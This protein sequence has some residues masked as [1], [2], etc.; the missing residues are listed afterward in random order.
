MTKLSWQQAVNQ[1]F[2]RAHT[3][4]SKGNEGQARVCARRAAGIAIGEYL[5]R[6][7]L[8]NPGP[9][10]IDRLKFLTTQPDISPEV[11]RAIQHL[12]QRVDTNHNLPAGVDLIQEAN[13][14][15]STLLPESFHLI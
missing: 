4:R 1:E 11:L 3:A 6:H 15:I 12:T 2:A 8:P 5:L 7:K 14:L 9:S 10:A 13:I